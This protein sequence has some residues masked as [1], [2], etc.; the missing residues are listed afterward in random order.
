MTDIMVEAAD[1]VKVRGEGAGRVE[2]LKSLSQSIHGM[3]PLTKPSVMI[4]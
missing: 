3:L 2:A 1:I 4:N